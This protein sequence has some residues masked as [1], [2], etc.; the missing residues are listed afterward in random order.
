MGKA[1]KYDSV[2][3]W[4]GKR[5]CRDSLVTGMFPSYKGLPEAFL[6]IACFEARVNI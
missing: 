2:R 1:D 4:G 6:I 5:T 3:V